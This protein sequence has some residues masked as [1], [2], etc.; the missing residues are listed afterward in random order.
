MAAPNYAPQGW[1]ARAL[2]KAAS[3]L[4]GNI[5]AVQGNRFNQYQEQGGFVGLMG[6]RQMAD[7]GALLFASM[8]PSQTA[9][10]LGLSAAYSAVAA[11]LVIKNNAVVGSGIRLGIRE[12]HFLCAI[13]PTS[14]TSLAYST[15]VDSGNRQPTTV[16]AVG[17]PATATAYA[18]TVATPNFAN[19]PIA[20]LPSVWFPLS[21]AGG[22]APTVPAAVNPVTIV[23]NGNLRTVI[24]VGVAATG[25]EDDYRIVFGAED[26]AS[27]GLLRS[28]AGA[29]QVIEPHPAVSLD[30]QAFFLL[31]LWSLGNITAGF[32]FGGLDVT[33]FLR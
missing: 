18:A 24:P 2:V 10:Q 23:G 33:M 8:T 11:A 1:V 31:N 29:L 14:G 30:P 9:L 4:D 32:A 22:A 5:S 28:S 26:R 21:T 19:S 6:E 27:S 12:I 16:A 3:M 15:V 25:V 13:P 20:A 7:E 17:S